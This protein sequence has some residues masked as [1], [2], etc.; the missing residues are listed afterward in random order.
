MKKTTTPTVTRTYRGGTITGPAELMDQYIAELDARHAREERRIEVFGVG[1]EERMKRLCASFPTLRGA[2]GTAPWNAD[3]FVIWAC[4]PE[5]GSGAQHAA[6]FVL[7]VWNSSTDWAE[8]AGEL[9]VGAAAAADLGPFNVVKAIGT[10][11][12]SHRAAFV[13]WAQLPFWP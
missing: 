9:G 7:T 3:K 10:W 6:R 1:T 2:A 8:V 12:A 13:A 11:D 5:P 4:G